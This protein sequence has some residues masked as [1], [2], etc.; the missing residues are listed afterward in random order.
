MINFFTNKTNKVNKQIRNYKKNLI[1]IT[2]I[3]RKKIKKLGQKNWLIFFVYYLMLP[4]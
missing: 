1:I 4:K 2:T 3:K